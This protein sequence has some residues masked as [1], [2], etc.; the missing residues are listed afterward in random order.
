MKYLIEYLLRIDCIQIQIEYD[1][2]SITLKEFSSEMLIIEY[3]YLKSGTEKEGRLKIE[4]PRILAI[5]KGQNLQFLK[6]FKYI[7]SLIL[8]LDPKKTISNEDVALFGSYD[9]LI[10]D[11]NKW[12][13]KHLT[14]LKDF[15]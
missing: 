14:P 6:W 7:W 5:Y 2:E 8:K 3:K 10:A 9:I 1:L 13:K 4:L 12:N 11:L 15:W